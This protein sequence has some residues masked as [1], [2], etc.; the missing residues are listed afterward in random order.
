MRRKCLRSLL[1]TI[2]VDQYTEQVE[3]GVEYTISATLRYVSE[4]AHSKHEIR[5]L[6][7]AEGAP[8]IKE[9]FGRNPRFTDT[10]RL[11]SV[12]PPICDK[13][14]EQLRNDGSVHPQTMLNMLEIGP[15]ASGYVAPDPTTV[16]WFAG[17]EL[18]LAEVQALPKEIDFTKKAAGAVVLKSVNQGSCGSC[19]A[20]AAA[21]AYSYRLHFASRG[22]YN[23]FVSPQSG[24]SCTNGCDGGN[25]P[26]VYKAQ[27]EAQGFTP[28]WC[29]QYKWSKPVTTTCSK[30]CDTSIKYNVKG[31]YTSISRGHYTKRSTE[32]AAALLMKELV[33][34]GPMPCALK[35]SSK[36]QALKGEGVF[37]AKGAVHMPGARATHAVTLV[38]YGTLNGADYWLIQNS[39]GAQWGFKGYARIARGRDTLGFESSG[40]DTLT[41]IVPTE[42]K[43]SAACRNG[44]SFMKDCSCHCING[45]SGST[46]GVC[47]KKCT[48]DR[49][50][51]RSVVNRGKCTCPCKTGYYTREGDSEYCASKIYIADST[52]KI[53][54]LNKKTSI[55]VNRGTGGA[56]F[57]AGDMYIAVPE[58]I[59]PYSGR[60]GW[61]Q[62]GVRTYVCGESGKYYCSS[63]SKPLPEGYSRSMGAFKG[64]FRPGT[65]EVYVFKYLGKNEFGQ[66]KGWKQELKLSQKFVVPAKLCRDK[67][68]NCGEIVGNGKQNC[69]HGS[70]N[71]G[72]PV[73][74]VCCK[75]CKAIGVRPKWQKASLT[76]A[77]ATGGSD[78]S[79]ASSG[80]DDSTGSTGSDD[81]T[82]SSGS[83]DSTASSGSDDS[84]SSNA[85]SK[86][87]YPLPKNAQCK[88]FCSRNPRTIGVKGCQY[89]Q[90]NGCSTC[91]TAC[92]DRL[93][94]CQNLV[95]KYGCK[96][97]VRL[98]VNGVRG[99]IPSFCKKSCSVCG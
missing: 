79:T 83:D 45:F 44:G 13:K 66:S 35:A 48:G 52:S 75:S 55:D 56:K 88:G 43:S 14:K 63:P 31:P 97:S 41:A 39:W 17:P 58:G 92:R 99:D 47:N 87:M 82:A 24:M 3:S 60:E 67:W 46:C 12:V 7:N 27:S 23:I 74:D 51:G 61:A 25:A 15:R 36:L 62:T 18:S 86:C 37:N 49:E 73:R 9:A 30:H 84:G 85:S 34:N 78:D 8:H 42:C 50:S 5:L 89:R 21:I 32:A 16:D 77:S 69:L 59:K 1:R 20:F 64:P 33:A 70:D 2:D 95:D 98:K 72:T 96:G 68:G 28:I 90:C 26:S 40:C 22:H 94:G 65:Y 53:V 76:S 81:S 6:K 54:H 10:F 71:S 11:L 80:S 4:S 38:G 19:Y 93:K 57:Y 29:S 91:C